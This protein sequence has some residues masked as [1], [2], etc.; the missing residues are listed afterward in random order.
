MLKP[1]MDA[2]RDM[3]VSLSNIPGESTPT[4]GNGNIFVSFF[5]TKK[6]AKS[7]NVTAFIFIADFFYCYTGPSISF[8]LLEVEISNRGPKKD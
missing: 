5:Y 2:V 4:I 1:N 6:W 7:E 3:V 8:F